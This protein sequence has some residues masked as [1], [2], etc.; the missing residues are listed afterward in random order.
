V[1]YLTHGDYYQENVY[2]IVIKKLSKL[3]F[4]IKITLKIKKCTKCAKLKS[5]YIPTQILLSKAVLIV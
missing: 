3:K 5:S 2:V 4:K 1:Q